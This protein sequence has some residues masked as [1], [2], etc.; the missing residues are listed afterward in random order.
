MDPV[1]VGSADPPVHRVDV[2]RRGPRLF[3]ASVDEPRARRAS[4]VILLVS[5]A[6]GL[7]LMTA[8][9]EPLPGFVSSVSRFVATWPDFLDALWQFFVD[10][11]VILAV[12]L[13]AV[14]FLRRRTAVGRDLVLSVVVA[15][16][17]WLLLSRGVAGSWPPV[18]ESLRSAA[19]PLQ[20]PAP[21]VALP[22]AVVFTASPHLAL[23]VRRL[24]RWVVALAAIGVMMIGASTA[25]G[26]AAGV[27]VATLSA[28]VVHLAFG[29]SGGRPSLSLVRDSLD[30]LGVP[31][32]S[33]G[34]ADRQQAGVFLVNAAGVYG[35]RLIVKVYG[36]DAHDT[37]LVS[38]LWRTV[39]YREPGSPL[40]FA[41]GRQV[42]HEAFLTLFAGQAGVRTDTVVTAGST[43]DDDALLVLRRNGEL[44]ADLGEDRRPTDVDRLVAGIWTV[45]QQL[46]DGGVAHGQVDERHILV[47]DG[48]P[49]LVDFRGASVAA[50][51]N[52]R[53]T[54]LVQALV[55]T[56]LILGE[57]RAV[58]VARDRLGSERLVSILPLLQPSVLTPYQRDRIEEDEMGLDELRAACA[59]AVGEEPPALQ[60]MR[61]ITLGSIV[62]VV[63]P[64]VAVLMLLS[65]LAGLDFA[66]LVEQL[67]NA[68]WWLLVL[69][70]I[71]SQLPRLTQAISTLGSSPVPLP[72]GPV[73]ALQLAVSYVNIAIPTAAARI[74]VNIRFF[75]R[76]GVP[77]GAALAAGA[78]D[79][80][81]GFVVQA[82]LLVG[83]LLM[84]SAT[85]DLDLRAAVDSAGPIL[86]V[87]VVIAVIAVAVS[88]A[89]GRLRRFITRWARQLSTEALSAVRGLRSPRRGLM[90]L[91]GNLGSE[92]LFATALGIFARAFG[93]D[94]ALGELLLISIGVGLLS[95][96]IPVPGGIGVAEGG[97]TFGLVQAGVPEEIAFAA[98]LL[99]RLSTFYLPPIWGFFAMRWLERNEH[100]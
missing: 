29:S 30:E 53:R 46:Q 54:D 14:A 4:D 1:G 15:A 60:V 16:A 27:L 19:P 78:L 95:G 61:R 88:L 71:V 87:V 62:R 44:L 28:A 96:L 52:Q 23:P 64:A 48:G 82:L 13:A 56:R 85:L 98:V 70:V 20:F 7:A 18:W 35:D 11:L 5:T 65:G 84:T 66:E 68:E 2:I 17:I 26:A 94:I 39:W 45:V 22:A 57:E 51:D 100:L 47:D 40:R 58:A 34:V 74:A 72:L 67:R 75:Q 10:L 36:R 90:L 49:G 97:L 63:L 41:R 86:L 73:Y 42:E 99:Y 24:G 81:G 92:V 6:V 50:T 8:A 9:T 12:L 43:V 77:P 37:A 21:R 83:L 91:G 38:T 33:L 76:H 32:S 89:F 80:F 93:F 69:G 59:T 55:T 31:I 79:G 3:A 25:L